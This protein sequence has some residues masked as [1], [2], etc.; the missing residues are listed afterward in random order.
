MIKAIEINLQRGIKLLNS[1]SDDEYSNSSIGPYYSSIGCHVRHILDIYTCIFKGIESKK[2][3]F[4]NREKN[5]RIEFKTALG[6]DYFAFVIHQLKEITL[7]YDES[8]L[9][10]VCDDLGLETK[11]TTSTL[12]S[13]LMQADSHTT[14]HYASIGYLIYHLEIELPDADF[15]FNPSTIKKSVY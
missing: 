9:L 1:I 7:E 4:T 6:V 13:I 15:G 10:E 11:T 12:G 5:H 8:E 14:H 2:I 3:D